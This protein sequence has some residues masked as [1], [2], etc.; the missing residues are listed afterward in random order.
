[1]VLLRLVLRA[2]AF[3]HARAVPVG[4]CTLRLGAAAPTGHAQLVAGVVP[5]DGVIDHLHQTRVSHL[6]NR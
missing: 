2:L 6:C 3:V 5:Q 1:M 4:V